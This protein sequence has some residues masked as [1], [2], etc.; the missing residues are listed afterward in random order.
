[1]KWTNWEIERNK[2]TRSDKDKKDK[3]KEN[4]SKW[5]WHFQ[6]VN[7]EDEVCDLCFRRGGVG[8]EVDF[9]A[10]LHSFLRNVF[11][12]VETDNVEGML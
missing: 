7:V 11:L 6:F 5:G 2:V 10:Y 4:P 12:A 8:S 1:M 9:E 3:T